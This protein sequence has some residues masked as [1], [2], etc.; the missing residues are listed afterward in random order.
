MDM[1]TRSSAV[2]VVGFLWWSGTALAQGPPPGC[3]KASTPDRFEGQVVRVDPARN[4]VTVRGTDGT[5][6]EFE[7]EKAT[8]QDLKVG[9]KIDAKLRSSPKC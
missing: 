9:N 7:A 2:V 5:I 3:D 1:W 6:H 8:L 4:R